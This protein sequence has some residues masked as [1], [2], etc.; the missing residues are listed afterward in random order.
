MEWFSHVKKIKLTG[1]L[2]PGKGKA[3]C[4]GFI[5]HGFHGEVRRG[6]LCLKTKQIKLT[7][8]PKKQQN[9]QNQRSGYIKLNLSKLKKNTG[10]K[11]TSKVNSETTLRKYVFNTHEDN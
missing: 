7:N 9:T 1:N 3:I 10:I 6:L 8:Q 11:Q 4:L 2:R 5:K